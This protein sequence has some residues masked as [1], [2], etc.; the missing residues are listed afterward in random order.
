MITIREAVKDDYPKLVEIM[1]KAADKKEL[2]GFVPP[3]GVTRK[4]LVQLKRQLE[5]VEHGVFVAE[6][7]Q[8]PVGFVFFTQKGDHF[9]I[10]EIDVIKEYQG[11]GIGRALVNM[12]ERIAR[13]KGVTSLITG[14]SINTEG[15]PWKAY[16]FW[17]RM[18]YKDTGERTESGYGFKY[19]NLVKR[20]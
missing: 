7:N 6:T 5:L 13:A 10:E 8:K 17:I 4:F 2:E 18:G 11:Q 15:E 14:T 1:K 3:E 16:G 20:L 9:E 12:V 19:C